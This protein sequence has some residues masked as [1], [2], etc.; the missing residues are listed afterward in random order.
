MCTELMELENVGVDTDFGGVDAGIN[1]VNV[2]D[3]ID[4]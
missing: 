4:L 1:N 2:G 3:G